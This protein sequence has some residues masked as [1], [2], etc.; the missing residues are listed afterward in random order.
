MRFTSFRL[1]IAATAALALASCGGSGGRRR[2]RGGGHDER[3]R[4]RAPCRTPCDPRARSPSRPTRPTRRSSSWRRTGARSTGWTPTWPPRWPSGWDLSSRSSTRR[5]TASSPGSRPGSTTSGSPAS[6][7]RSER[8][9]TVDFVTYFSAGTSLFVRAGDGARPPPSRD[10]CGHA[11]AVQKGT[12]QADDAAAQDERCRSG[13]A[14][15]RPRPAL[16][17]P[18]RREPRARQPARRRRDGRLPGRGLRGQERSG[19]R[20]KLAGH[21]LRHGAVR[22]RDPEGQRHGRARPAP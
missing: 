21:R 16:P 19:G 17:G 10:L 18:A 5:S 3:L 15:G 8:E 20:F 14:A 4:R 9:K 12:V 6:R 22:D 2:E 1:V 13:A 11:V 7:T